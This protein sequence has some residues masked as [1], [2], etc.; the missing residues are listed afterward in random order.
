MIPIHYYQFCHGASYVYILPTTYALY[1]G[2][3]GLSLATLGH[4]V[5]CD[6]YWKQS[7]TPN[8]VFHHHFYLYSCLLFSLYCVHGYRT[9]RNDILRMYLSG[10]TI[11]GLSWTYVI[12]SFLYNI[13]DPSWKFYFACFHGLCSL[14][15][16]LVLLG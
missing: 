14:Q 5:M 12:S 8:S 1:K 10:N 15:Q 7:R 16:L 13:Q 6:V 11:M 9:I 2:H 4:S 3:F